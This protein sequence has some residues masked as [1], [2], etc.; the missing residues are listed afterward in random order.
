MEGFIEHVMDNYRKVMWELSRDRR[1]VEVPWMADAFRKWLLEEDKKNP[2]V[3]Y[4]YVQYLKALDANLF[5]ADEEAYNEDA[6]FWLMLKE[7]VLGGEY[8]EARELLEGCL[9]RPGL[10]I[11]GDVHE[12]YCMAGQPGMVDISVNDIRRCVGLAE[13]LCVATACGSAEQALRQA[14]DEVFSLLAKER[15]AVVSALLWVRVPPDCLPH[16]QPDDDPL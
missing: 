3:P 14:M 16:H 1:G 10:V 4:V 5:T 8:D 6:D 9:S 15:L 13:V 7:S 12:L 11:Y 2:S